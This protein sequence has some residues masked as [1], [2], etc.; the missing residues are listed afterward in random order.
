MK[1]KETLYITLIVIGF[2][3]G[4][5][6]LFSVSPIIAGLF[7]AIAFIVLVMILGQYSCEI[8]FTDFFKIKI[9][10]NK[11]EPLQK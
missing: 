4:G 2:L 5:I 10:K 1:K 9:E 7:L 3:G 6:V 8:A 11:K